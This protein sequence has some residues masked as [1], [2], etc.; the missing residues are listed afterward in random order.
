ME[1]ILTIPLEKRLANRYISL[2]KQHQHSSPSCAPGPSL[3]AGGGTALSSVQALWRFLSNDRVTPSALMEPL[4]Q[5]ARDRLASQSQEQVALLIHDWTKLSYSHHSS[6][7]DRATLTHEQDVGYELA[8]SLLVNTND[9]SPVAPLQMYLR[10]AAKTMMGTGTNIWDA[11][12]PHIEQILPTMEFSK[13]WGLPKHLVHVI[14]REVDSVSH[15]RQWDQAG[16]WF[17]VRGDDRRV[18]WPEKDD[19]NSV[20]VSHIDQVLQTQKGFQKIREISYRGHSCSQYV[21]Q[22][23]VILHRPGRRRCKDIR[24]TDAGKPLSLRLVL[25]HLRDSEGRILAKWWLLSNVPEKYASADCLALWYYWRWRI[26]SFFKLLKSGG[27]QVEAW[28][29]TSGPA[30]LRRLLIASMACV[31]AWNLEQDT[32]PQGLQMQQVLIRLSGR[33]MKRSRPVTASALLAG[34]FVLLPM[35]ELLQEYDGDLSQFLNLAQTTL[36]YFNSG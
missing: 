9:G 15:Y 8:T 1:D 29:Q 20:L 23:Q 27:Q 30:I 32:S 22:T 7:Q 11:S 2:V 19:K 12:L 26:E 6:K 24:Y 10:Y 3:G 21:A 31:L 33:Q 17:L 13:S 14:D 5:Q 28:Q 34:L 18:L 4:L 25:A 16:Y 36:P 35:L